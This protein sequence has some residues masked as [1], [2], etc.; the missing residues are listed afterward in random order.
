[1]RARPWRPCYDGKTREVEPHPTA[2]FCCPTGSALF[3]S[4][5]VSAFGVMNTE[6]IVSVILAAAAVVREPAVSVASQALADLYAAAK[7]YVRKK[8]VDRR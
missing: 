5:D 3:A 2:A 4:V 6:S 8:R 7:Y 1:M